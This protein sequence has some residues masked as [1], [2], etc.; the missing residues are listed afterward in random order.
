M[1]KSVEAGG[2]A[3]VGAL[4]ESGVDLFLEALVGQRPAFEHAVGGEDVGL[5][6]G[7]GLGCGDGRALL[8]EA[9]NVDAGGGGDKI[10]KLITEGA[11][12]GPLC[13]S[14]GPLREVEIGVAGR[15]KEFVRRAKGSEIDMKRM[16]SGDAGA[17]LRD[18]GAEATV[19]GVKVRDDGEPAA[20]QETQLRRL[21]DGRT[22][23]W[24]R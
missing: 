3:N 8:P 5:A 1:G 21:K 4:K 10:A 19:P 12:A 18:Y 11:V 24:L 7:A 20:L 13:T 14:G 22:S 2:S 16:L 17:E 15:G 9:V 23:G 6:E